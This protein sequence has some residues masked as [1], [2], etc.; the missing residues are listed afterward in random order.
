MDLLSTCRSQLAY[1]RIKELKDVLTQLG[2]SKQGKK[3][4]LMDRILGLISDEEVSSTHGSAKKKIIGKEGVAKLIDDAY[5]KMQIADESDLATRRQTSSLD[6]CNVKH[7]VEA[8]D[9]S[10]SAVKICCPCGSSLHTDPMI[11]CIDPG[12]RV[13]QHVSCVIIPEK[14]MEVI[15]SVP[16]IFHCEM[17]RISRAD[18]FCVTVAHLIS[19][20][21]LIAANIPSDG[22]NPLLNVE[23][24]FH[25]TKADSDSLQNTEYDIQAWC[26]LLNDNVSFRM[27][28][29]QYADLHVNGFAVR[30]LN[31][32]GSQLLGANGR[33]DGALITLYVVEGI[34]KIS[35]SACDARSFCF[36]VRLVKRHTIEQVLG[37][38]PKEADGESFKDA[39]AR[40]CRCVGGGMRTANEDSDSDL[41][42]I[43]DT[44]TVNL[45][46]PMS[47]SRI[48]VAG[49]FKPCVH[50]GCF[51]LE[52]FVELNQRSRKW[53]CP[54]CLKN[55]S[56]EDII[57]DPYFNRITTMMLHCGEDV[58]DIEV[59]PD[60][61][62]TVKTK[63]E[64]SDLGKWHFPDG[65]L[66]GD[67]NEVISNS[68]T[69]RQI[70]KHEKSGNPNLENGTEGGK[71]EA[72]EHQHLP[73]R[74]PK[75]ED[76][77]N[78][79][80][81]VITLSSSASGSGRDDEN[82]SINQDYGRYDS[83][84]GMNGNEINSI[85]HN[86]N[87]ILS[88]ENQ[89]YGAIGE[90]DIIIVSD[91]EEEDVNLVS[92]HTDYKSCVLNDCGALSAP[93]RIEQSY[94]ENPVPDS[95]ISSC[96]DLFNDSGKDVGMSD[97]AY[98][99]GTQASS[100]FQLFG[101]DS[102]VSDV[103]IDL[104]RSGVTCSGPMNSYTLASKLTMNSSRQVPDSSIFSTNINEDDDLVDNPFAFVSVDPSLQNFLST[105]PVGTLAETDLG[106]CPPISNITHT[107]DWIS[108][109]LGCNGESIGSSVG[110]IAQ[111][112]VSKGLDLINDCRSN[113]G[114]NDKARSNRIDNRKKLNGPFSFPR[115]PRSVRR[116][117]YS[118]ASDS[119]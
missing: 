45:R 62:W 84:P 54:I 73:L 107:E 93:P 118:I 26:V 40:V 42:V 104:E 112:A 22:T 14:P 39:L 96:L 103:L 46:C 105:Q 98:S 88:T 19:P 52:T 102:D 71:I 56:L 64:L 87:S 25:L 116:R 109:R 16:A 117:G 99:S 5:R 9:F 11:Q 95:G 10:Y 44:I 80:Q 48:K 106:H 60:G 35:L 70:N 76:L 20:V 110:T 41:E 53:Q 91:S 75:E 59:K 65:S 3:Q 55:Y 108:L 83:I 6:I 57:I 79:C 18:P 115:Q 89:S 8:E 100:R 49:R 12:C 27:Q 1:F 81:M 72:S 17:C 97:W 2:I 82:P 30:T 68:E 50:M 37:L 63:D 15:P 36:G 31:R 74:N 119:N 28:W 33:D 90:P 32:P 114:M 21:K 58:T 43:A 51:D 4:D 13:Q 66:H 113:E 7:K 23:K 86:F 94:L 92:C 69:W 101:E 24:T 111:S 61:S 77:E 29:P 34:N 85:R 47:G 67:M 38:I 78:F